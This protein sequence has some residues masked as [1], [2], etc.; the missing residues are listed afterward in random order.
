MIPHPLRAP[1]PLLAASILFFGAAY[2]TVRFPNTPGAGVGSFASTLF[3][4]LPSFVALWRYLGPKVATLSLLSMSALGFAVETIGVTTGFPY[5]PFYYGGSLGPKVADLVP[6]LLPLSWVPLVLGAVAAT[7][8]FASGVGSRVFP[9]SPER[10]VPRSGATRWWV[11]S[12]AVLLTLVDG[13]LDPGAAALGFWVW[14]EGGIYYG[15]PITNYLGWLFSSSLAAALLIALG[16]RR[17][18][19]VP[20]PPGLLDSA[21]I[22]T[23]FWTG[24]AV[25]SGL[26][27]PVVLG[28]AL[29]LFLLHRRSGL[30]VMDGARYKGG[31]N[32]DTR[33]LE[34]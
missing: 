26:S 32:G 34:A 28:A 31:E 13:V 9:Y 6:Y 17:W 29:Y 23:A 18:G 1:R 7:S 5:G 27:F 25:F 24:V 19:S 15:V 16:R 11:L 22:A 10:S 20:P 2:F 21:L 3:I 8:R 33:R 30:A 4:A 12:A 14:P